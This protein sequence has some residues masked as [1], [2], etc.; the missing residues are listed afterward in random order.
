[1]QRGGPR[2]REK[3]TLLTAKEERRARALV[4]ELST[5]LE[6]NITFSTL[7]RSL[8]RIAFVNEKKIVSAARRTRVVFK[9]PMRG[10]EK[11]L[12]RQDKQLAQLIRS[13]L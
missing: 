2:N 6:S 7:V 8:L 5:R 10:S 11:E 9:S 3:R 13:V 1:M 4:A 12:Q